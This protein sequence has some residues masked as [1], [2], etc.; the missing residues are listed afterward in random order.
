M[1][2]SITILP[3]SHVSS[4]FEA[5][6]SMSVDI[7]PDL[8]KSHEAPAERV[9]QQ[10]VTSLAAATSNVESESLPKSTD[11]QMATVATADPIET[12]EQ[13]QQHVTT[14]KRPRE[15]DQFVADFD[16]KRSV[17]QSHIHHIDRESPPKSRS[18]KR[19]SLTRRNWLNEIEKY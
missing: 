15:D 17:C 16:A 5:N 8:T 7:E 19:A 6:E 12:V 9:E 11:A 2:S 18:T 1:L 3:Q 14:T 13:L 10:E 4:A